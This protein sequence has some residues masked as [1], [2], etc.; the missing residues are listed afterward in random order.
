MPSGKDSGTAWRCP[1]VSKS[2][3]QSD[4]AVLIRRDCLAPSI[5]II[6]QE[7]LA[8]CN[9]GIDFEY[10]RWCKSLKRAVIG[11]V[12]LGYWGSNYLR[13]LSRSKRVEVRYICDKDEGRLHNQRGTVGN[14]IFTNRFQDIVNDDE[15][16]AVV[17][18]TPAS[19]HY[20]VAREA[21]RKH[22]DVLIEKPMT[23][24]YKEAVNLGELAT[25]Q[26]SVV[27][28]GHIY[29]YNPSVEYMKKILE[30]RRLGELFYGTGL[31]MGLGPIRSDASCTWDLATHDVAILDYLLGIMPV[32]VTADGRS[33]L[34]KDREVYDYATIN[35]KY[36]DGF[37]FNL[38]VSWYAAE[39]IRR[40]LLVGSDGMVRFDDMVK[41]DPVTVYERNAVSKSN[42]GNG[43]SVIVREGKILNPPITSVEPLSS[44]VDHFIDAIDG[45]CK[46]MTDSAQG[47]RVVRVME[48]IELSIK[49]G[50][51]PVTLN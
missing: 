4:G 24:N 6:T 29:C 18:A 48:A 9:H 43:P 32:S 1:G 39:K 7:G 45:K 42:A 47:A 51:A 35:M 28:V 38:V 41:A 36:A 15:V 13:I 19:T 40:W 50:S 12:G 8:W 23:M 44:E 30:T 5:Y 46:P 16:R 14:A 49:R 20:K 3:L 34:R 21:L 11:L 17:I 27:M 10:G 2:G 33:F 31:R 26:K 25:K 22:K 37:I